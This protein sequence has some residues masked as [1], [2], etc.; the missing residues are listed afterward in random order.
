VWVRVDR[1][2]RHGS[3]TPTAGGG[4]FRYC[5]GTC[6]SVDAALVAGAVFVGWE[7]D[8]ADPEFVL[9]AL[10]HGAGAFGPSFFR[11]HN[12]PNC[13]LSAGS[14]HGCRGRPVAA[15][16]HRVALAAT[17]FAGSFQA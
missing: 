6:L 7:F 16:L 17:V 8:A 4:Q 9:G 2:S 3:F 5:C 1:P 10:E 13:T 11:Y 12:S 15:L 14:A